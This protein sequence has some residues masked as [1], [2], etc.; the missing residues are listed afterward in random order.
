M[1]ILRISFIVRLDEYQSFLK[2]ERVQI[3]SVGSEDGMIITI[4]HSQVEISNLGSDVPTYATL[5]KE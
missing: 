5:V 4:E 2:G 3:F 1:R